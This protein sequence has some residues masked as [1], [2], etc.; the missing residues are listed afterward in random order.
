M[1]AATFDMEESSPKRGW[2]PQIAITVFLGIP[3]TLALTV[4]LVFYCIY[5]RAKFAFSATS[6][7]Q[8]DA[9][10]GEHAFTNSLTKFARIH[11]Q[12]VKPAAEPAVEKA[13]KTTDKTVDRA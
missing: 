13:D 7:S 1:A 12:T 2:L 9:H 5:E 6:G 4:G 8:P 11:G 10:S 3:M